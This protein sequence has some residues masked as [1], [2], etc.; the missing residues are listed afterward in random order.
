MS[1]DPIVIV[2]GARTPVIVAVT[3]VG[4]PALPRH[5]AHRKDPVTM[6]RSSSR[7]LRRSQAGQPW[8]AHSDIRTTQN[9]TPTQYRMR[10]ATRQTPLDGR[11]SLPRLWGGRTQ[12]DSADSRVTAGLDEYRYRDSNPGFRR[13]RAIKRSVS[14]RQRPVFAG[15]DGHELTD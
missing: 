7:F 1:D 6:S 2:G 9:A 15:I 13:E 12:R 4:E 3:G 5:D 10:N 14:I 8:A 11:I